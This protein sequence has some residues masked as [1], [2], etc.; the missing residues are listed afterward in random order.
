MSD[1]DNIFFNMN[2]NG[3]NK[4]LN[5]HLNEITGRMYIFE[6][7][8]FCGYSTFVYVYKD[9]SMVELFNRIS[10]HFGCRNIKGLYI[11]PT[12]TQFITDMSNNSM[13]NNSMSNNSMED[14]RHC[15]CCADKSD[16]FVQ[17][18]FFSFKKVRDFVFDNISS[19]SSGRVILEPIYALP[20][21]VVYRLY[22]DDG[23]CH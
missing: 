10:Y 11:G 19:S 8:K 4:K 23:H 14:N 9:E 3:Y 15:I 22:L 1:N 7:T 21:P 2:S 20:D 18:P 6:V 16:K 17:V 5:E 13:S 12:N